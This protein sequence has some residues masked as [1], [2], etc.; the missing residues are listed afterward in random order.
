[1]PMD[2]EHERLRAEIE[3]LR[4]QL[5]DAEDAL[6]A[7]RTGEVDALV[8]QTPAGERVFALESAY[9][10]YRVF[11]E[12]MEQ[13][14][15]TLTPDG[16]ILYANSR[17]AEL[18]GVP[19]ARLV[20]ASIYEVLGPAHAPILRSLLGAP[21]G[22]AHEAEIVLTRADARTV[23]TYVGVTVMPDGARCAVVTDLTERVRLHE[24]LASQEWLR[25]TLTSI[26]DAVLS[27]DVEGR[28]TFLNPVAETLTGWSEREAL[29]RPIGEVFRILDEETREAAE[30]LAGR[31]LRDGT[32]A[33]LSNHAAIVTRDGGQVSIEDSAAPIRD[34]AG[35]LVGVVLVFHDVT[36]KRAARRA[37]AISQAR[38]ESVLNSITNGYY[39]LD[40]DWRFAAANRTAERHF[41]EPPG[42]LV[43]RSIWTVIGADPEAIQYQRF[44][45]VKRTSAPAHFEA[46]ST[47]RA[48]VWTEMHA[49][50]LNGGLEVYFADI[51]E[52]KRA[53]DSLR[54]ALIDLESARLSAERAKAAAEE[55][56]QA[57]DRFLAVLSHELR[58]PLSPVLTGISLLEDEPLSRQ[59]RTYLDVVRRNVQ[60]ESRLIDDLL[61]VTRIAHGRIQMNLETVRLADVIDGA[62]EVCR[63]DIDAREL[64]FG[65][66]VNEP[67]DRPFIVQADP[68][69]LQQVF[70]NLLKNAVKFTPAGGRVAVACREDGGQAVVEV[71]DSGIG[72]EG[73][74][75]PRVFDAFAQAEASLIRQFG[76]LGLGLAISKALVDLHGGTIEAHSGGRDQGATFRVRLPLVRAGQAVPASGTRPAPQDPPARKLRILLVDDHGDTVD[77]LSTILEAEGHEVQT[78]GDVASALE[79]AARADF[80]LLLSDLGLPDRSGLELMREIRKRG[81][82]LPGIALSGYG[83]ERDIEQSR[84]AGFNEHL[85]KPA[86]PGVLLRAI[87]RVARRAG[88]S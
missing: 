83:H 3:D 11:L 4:A 73:D 68:A 59:A 38:L 62:I 71:T 46:R 22:R 28:V 57:K 65:V 29:G 32:A 76:G 51:S 44:H 6:R 74:M 50:P 55:A 20:G 70:W 8:V 52:R 34:A 45:E 75:L 16:L 48:D 35:K 17:L 23:H 56:G 67:A 80:D 27:C 19:H 47:V 87:E 9:E 40:E 5:A 25:V 18:T 82:T 1:M 79:A 66:A 41:G 39:A 24:I 26:G 36:E 72:I 63:P 86:E 21:T 37:L 10:Q 58:T 81:Q 85:V 31:V 14:A 33:A 42:T 43:G 64:R 7:I 30:D 69:R 88:A 84:A 78:A 13:G 53:E 15:A 2:A 77:M 12:N 60:L 61:D 49:Y 54:H